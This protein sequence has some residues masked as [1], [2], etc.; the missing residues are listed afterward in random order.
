VEKWVKKIP[1]RIPK[2]RYT[3]EEIEDLREYHLYQIVKQC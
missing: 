3:E 1:I 2:A